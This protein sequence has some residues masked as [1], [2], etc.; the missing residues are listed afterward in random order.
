M[1]GYAEHDEITLG[2]YDKHAEEYA[3][4]TLKTDRGDLICQ[5]LGYLPKADECGTILDLGCGPGRDAKVMLAAGYDVEPADGS[6]EMCRIAERVTGRV[7]RQ[8]LFSEL[9]DQDRYSGIWSCGAL[10]HVPRAEL[11]DVVGRCFDALVGGGVMYAS[12]KI[13]ERDGYSSGR[14]FTDLSLE[15]AVE[16][17]EGAGFEVLEAAVAEDNLGRDHRWVNLFVRK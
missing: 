13:G 6:A 4:E 1:S 2:Y 5:F 15:E 10:L 12:F 11:D 16:L 8:M 7:A 3:D 9:C 14:Y 17:F